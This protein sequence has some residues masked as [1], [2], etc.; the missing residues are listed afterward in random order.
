MRMS[1]ALL[2]G[3]PRGP[4][5]ARL[6]FASGRAVSALSP[7]PSARGAPQSK[8]VRI[9]GRWPRDL[10]QDHQSVDD[11]GTCE[12]Y[13][14]TVVLHQLLEADEKFSKPIVPST[15]A[16][17]DPTARRVSP[18]ARWTFAT[19]A[20][21][22]RV[23]S[24]SGC[25]LDHREIVPL[26]EAEVLRF[27]ERRTRAPYDNAVQCGRRRFHI[28]GVGAG[29]H[30]GQ[31]DAALVGQRVA[32]RAELAAVRRVGACLC[33]PNGALTTTLSSD[34]HRHWIPRRLSY[35][36]SSLAHSRSKIQA[37]THSWNRRW[38]V[39]PDPYSRGKAFHWQPV[40][41]TYRMPS[42]TWRKGTTG[43]PLVPGGFSG[44]RSG[45]S[46]A[47]RSSGIRQIVRN[48]RFDR[49]RVVIGVDLCC[50]EGAIIGHAKYTPSP[51]V[52]G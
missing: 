46:W 19:M 1:P 4:A 47:Q 30:D 38:Q 9:S 44:G 37:C 7:Q 45:W 35:R 5:K 10:S 42:I 2:D 32:L 11:E 29:H 23:M 34:C 15:S 43:R 52:L 18:A 31:R 3:S 49:C 16:L 17:N 27:L 20:E 26:I 8:S 48:R 28:V 13:Q 25:R 14:S 6:R 21:V 33:P 50:G 36:V 41:S 51:W 24:A 22:G 39:E 40:R 12:M